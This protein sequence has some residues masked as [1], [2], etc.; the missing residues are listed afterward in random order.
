MEN[1]TDAVASGAFRASTALAKRLAAAE[2]ELAQLEAVQAQRATPAVNVERP[3]A[4]LPTHA[5]RYLE[6]LEETLAAGDLPAAR[7]EIKAHVGTVTV[8]ADE[9]E[10]RL[11]SEQGVAAYLLRA[12]AG[13]RCSFVGSGAGFDP[14]LEVRLG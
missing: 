14:Y 6:R 8:E 13:S 4:E 9:Q 7:Q 1:L 11:W 5:V 2:E 12:A 3:L 10:I